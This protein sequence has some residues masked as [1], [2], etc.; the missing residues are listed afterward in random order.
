MVNLLSCE[1]GVDMELETHKKKAS[2]FTVGKW[3]KEVSV[4]SKI[5]CDVDTDVLPIYS[6]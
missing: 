5:S 2:A 6:M 1:D 3:S 4:I